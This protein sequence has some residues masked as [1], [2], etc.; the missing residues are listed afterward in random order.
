MK[1]LLSTNYSAWAFNTA[2]FVLRVA[3]GLMMLPHGYSKLIRFGDLQA[4]FTNFLGLGSTLS[5]GLVLFAE[6]I[7]SVF[8]IIGLF[9][10]FSV[11]P[12]IVVM[13]VALFKSHGG[14][15]FGA[16]E[17]AGLFLAGYIVILLVGPG[18]ASVDSMMGK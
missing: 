6:L 12:L 4:K 15:I 8:I 2:L 17:K 13:C 7:C 14:E 11:M 16:G 1:Q 10:R 5:L 9:T 3:L 18:K